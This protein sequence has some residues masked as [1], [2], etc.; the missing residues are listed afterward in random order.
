MF[1]K[2][3]IWVGLLL[4]LL[5]P[6]VVYI[7]LLQLFS[8]LEVKGAASGTGFSEN[9]R[10]RTMAIVALA[11]NLVLLNIYRRRRW[12]LVMRGI[13]IATTL[14]ALGWLYVFG[15]KLF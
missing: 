2:N 4:G 9:F 7:M 5:V 10:E 8:I 11:I 13:V 3:A 15:T 6:S 12:D 1:N 14:L